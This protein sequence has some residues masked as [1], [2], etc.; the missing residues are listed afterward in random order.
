M[1][2]DELAAF[3]DLYDGLGLVTRELGQA[4]DALGHVVDQGATPAELARILADV[5]A[6]VG[7]AYSGAAALRARYA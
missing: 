7:R 4:L 1:T 5:Y 2:A 6:R 3:G